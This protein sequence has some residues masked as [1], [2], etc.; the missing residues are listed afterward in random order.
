MSEIVNI[1]ITGTAN[2]AQV[3]TQLAALTA[4]MNKLNMSAAKNGGFS[5]S[6]VK[7]LKNAES[8]FLSSI[9][10][11]RAFQVETVNLSTATDHLTNNL[12]RAKFSLGQYFSM[13]KQGNKGIVNDLMA[14]AES[15]AKVV[16]STVVPSAVTQGQAHVIT[17]MNAQ[18]DA[19]I[20]NKI[21]QQALNSVWAQG[22]THLI[23]LGKNTQWAGRQLTVGFA[24]PV[25]AAGAAL[26]TMFY[27]TDKNLRMLQQVYGIG[28]QAGKK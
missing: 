23:N 12:T 8:K 27:N 4:E 18:A 19:T 3:K 16:Q 7:N 13:M 24:V 9:N 17:N 10:A 2:F 26:A 22:S 25:A 11:T 1:Q 21:Y 20:K 14:V 6:Q 15:Q 5:D 28:G